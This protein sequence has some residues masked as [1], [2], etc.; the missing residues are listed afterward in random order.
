MVTIAGVGLEVGS[1]QP[2][3]ASPKIN[4][5]LPSLVH[6]AANLPG[7]PPSNELLRVNKRRMRAPSH[8]ERATLS[9]SFPLAH[10]EV[11]R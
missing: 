10:Y 6:L 2:I 3:F 7:K 9:Q 11:I 5:S 8:W 4:I 1:L